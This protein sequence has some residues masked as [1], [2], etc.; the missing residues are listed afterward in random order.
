MTTKKTSTNVDASDLHKLLDEIAEDDR[1]EK[2]AAKRDAQALE[3]KRLLYGIIDKRMS[4]YFDS[5][6]GFYTDVQLAAGVRSTVQQIGKDLEELKETSKVD[7]EQLL[8][9]RASMERQ[10]NA[11]F[12]FKRLGFWARLGWMI[13]GHNEPPLG[14]THEA[15]AE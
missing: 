2:K 8:F 15:A 13:F 3:F 11:F 7:H 5:K 4:D 1:N 9:Y 14:R 12:R 10:R 6:P